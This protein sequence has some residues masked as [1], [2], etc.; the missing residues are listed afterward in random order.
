MI[1]CSASL[2]HDLWRKEM[3]DQR[4]LSKLPKCCECEEPIQDDTLFVFDDKII[5]ESC[6][7]LNHRRYADE[8]TQ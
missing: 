4:W 2:S 1:Y 5:C 6:L 3:D 8:F 7:E